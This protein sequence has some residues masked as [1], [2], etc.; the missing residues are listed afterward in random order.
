M[1]RA[2][3]LAGRIPA[4]R[5][6]GGAR[7]QTSSGGPRG[8]PRKIRNLSAPSS[9]GAGARRE[10]D[11]QMGLRGCLLRATRVDRPESEVGQDLLNDRGLVNE[12][13]DPHRAATAGAQLGIGLTHLFDQPNSLLLECPAWRG[14]RDLDD[15]VSPPGFTKL[16]QNQRPP[17]Q[18]PPLWD[19]HRRPRPELQPLS[20]V[21]WEDI[22][23]GKLSRA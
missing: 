19:H 5:R 3:C 6:A 20:I 11:C 13:D 2:V 9:A 1:M 16:F 21:T 10:G 14:R 7:K 17:L 4:P 8:R 22:N 12:G 15:R 23:I 18:R